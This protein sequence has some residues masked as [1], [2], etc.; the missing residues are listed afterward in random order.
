VTAPASSPTEEASAGEAQHDSRRLHRHS[1]PTSTR[2]LIGLA[3]AA[4]GVVYGDIG[5]SPLYA[6]RACF[7][8]GLGGVAPTPQNV[9]GVLSLVFWAL[10]LVVSVEYLVFVMRAD[11]RGEGGILTLVSL[12]TREAGRHPVVG[13]A[14]LAMG[15]FGTALLYGD[16][17]ITPA[18]SVLGAVEGLE[19]ATP[20]FRPYISVLAVGILVGL[21]S[22]QR[23]GTAGLA[24]LFSPITL[25]WF[26]SIATLGLIQV[27][28]APQV[29]AATNPLNA[30]EFLVRNRTTGFLTLG[31]VFLVVTG[32][33]ALYA[34]MGHFG[35]RPIRLAW[36]G[37]VLP[38]LLLNY[39][40]QGALL[41]ANPAAAENPFYRLVPE[42]LLYPM[43]VVATAAAVVASQAMITGAFSLTRQALQLGYVPR[44]T[45]IHTSGERQGQIYIPSV[46]WALMLA[47]CG[48]VIGFGSSHELA[49]AY[50]IA[51]T[52]TMVITTLLFNVVARHHLG[53]HPLKAA[54]VT[55]VFL[56]IN[57]SFF[58][59]NIV[60]IPHGG[61]FPLLVAAAV[62]IFMTTWR[63]G[64]SMLQQIGQRYSLPLDAVLS[65]LAR[66]Q[67]P[68]P[69]GT[70]VFMNA[71]PH[72]APL[73][74]LHHLKHN[75]LLHEKVVLLSLLTEDVPFVP[76]GM[77]IQTHERGL[78]VY[79]VTARYGYMETPNAP[80]ALALS[81]P[82][83]A[84]LNPTD[85]TYYLGRQTL[86]TTGTTRMARWKK[87][88]FR[89]MARNAQ[90]ATAYFGLPPNRVVELGAQ[91][92]L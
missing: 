42:P 87:K 40:G 4:L 25:V 15:L 67:L 69:P 65:D 3:F 76:L 5:T 52:T 18:I 31:F 73:V 50:G 71:D 74:L 41:L 60:K 30:I 59:A 84:F 1:H 91:V 46:N 6:L 53:W 35:K 16:G 62:Y 49:A 66:N 2:A 79:Q 12:A 75:K 8:E 17:M 81:E 89:F 51:V 33:E 92:Q 39:F 45:I 34:D 48:L 61:W 77:K 43:V 37:L 11:N 23:R 19:V 58:A 7:A 90:P 36:F 78:G 26:L 22:L 47:S 63:D 82:L 20:A 56:P 88:L 57:L 10:V 44:M 38:A 83:Q 14:L 72:G 54:L 86:I 27:V 80:E 29:L 55:G 32:A 13:K 68:R 21:F 9:F 28:R 85:T 24:A 70:A 64:R